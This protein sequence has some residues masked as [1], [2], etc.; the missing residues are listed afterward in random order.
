[1]DIKKVIVNSYVYKDVFYIEIFKYIYIYIY[2]CSNIYSSLFLTFLLT[3]EYHNHHQSYFNGN[4]ISIII[5]ISIIF[6]SLFLS[7]SLISSL[8]IIIFIIVFMTYSC[9]KDYQLI[10]NGNYFGLTLGMLMMYHTELYWL[11]IVCGLPIMTL[12]FI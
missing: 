9:S 11:F 1:M 10:S 12:T 3:T 4:H 2:K 8:P 7:L 6:C 5:I